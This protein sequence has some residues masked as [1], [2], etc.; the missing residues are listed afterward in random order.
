MRRN[1]RQRHCAPIMVIS[2]NARVLAQID[3]VSLNGLRL[4]AALA[5]AC[6]DLV[7]LHGL[8]ARV[9]AR[10]IWCDGGVFGLEFVGDPMAGELR[11]FIA[12]LMRA[13]LP[14]RGAR[15]HGFTEL[16]APQPALPDVPPRPATPPPARPQTGSDVARGG[17]RPVGSD[18]NCGSG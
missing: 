11:R 18:R 6:G 13:P 15:M 8:G 17:H 7:Q 2:G 3:D 9:H 1:V 4:R 14:R 5:G 16:A 10:V 12:A